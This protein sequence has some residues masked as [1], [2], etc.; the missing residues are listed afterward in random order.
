MLYNINITGH[1][2]ILTLFVMSLERSVTLYNIKNF[3]RCWK[4]LHRLF[5]SGFGAIFSEALEYQDCPLSHL[6]VEPTS[7]SGFS[8]H[9]A[10][11]LS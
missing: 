11:G 2:V 6:E 1:Y 3:Y 9:L 8:E 5:F 7:E 10:I 4:K